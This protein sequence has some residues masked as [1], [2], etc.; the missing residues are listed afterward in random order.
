MSCAVLLH[1]ITGSPDPMDTLSYSILQCSIIL[2]NISSF[3]CCRATEAIECSCRRNHHLFPPHRGRD[4]VMQQHNIY[5]PHRGRFLQLCCRGTQRYSAVY[6]ANIRIGL[7]TWQW[8]QMLCHQL[9]YADRIWSL[10]TVIKC[11]ISSIAPVR[12]ACFHA[13]MSLYGFAILYRTPRSLFERFKN[14]HHYKYPISCAAVSALLYR[15]TAM[16]YCYR[17]GYTTN[18]Q[19]T[20]LQSDTVG[21]HIFLHD[22]LPV[23]EWLT[24]FLSFP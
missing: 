9:S 18:L 7:L 15:A 10:D 23:L 5:P 2:T 3:P 24:V 16:Q 12:L 14:F 6:W 11:S 21:I 1:A 19:Q 22:G 20:A 17:Y 4:V 13:K 8:R